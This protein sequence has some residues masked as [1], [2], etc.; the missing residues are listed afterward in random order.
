MALNLGGERARKIDITRRGP[1]IMNR[2]GGRG[3]GHAWDRL[4]TG[5]DVA[6]S[7]YTEEQPLLH[8]GATGVPTRGEFDEEAAAIPEVTSA[9]LKKD[10]DKIKSIT[11][12]I[13]A[14]SANGSHHLHIAPKTVDVFE[15]G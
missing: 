3:G 10:E 13:P 11:K 6:V 7:G 14:P 12:G 2:K 15:N 8:N 9:E 4:P 5:G 1:A